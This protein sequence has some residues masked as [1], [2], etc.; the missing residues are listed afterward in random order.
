MKTKE[1]FNVG[2]W[3]SDVIEYIER[4]PNVMNPDF[5]GSIMMLK[6]S[7]IKQRQKDQETVTAMKVARELILA[8]GLE[9]LD[10]GKES[11]AYKLLNA[12][13]GDK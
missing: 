4:Y 13:I 12:A 8:H 7:I 5:A 3:A 6:K 2:Y 9:K 11:T 10:S 1:M